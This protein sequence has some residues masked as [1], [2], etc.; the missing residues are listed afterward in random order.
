MQARI[1]GRPGGV[2]DLFPQIARLQRLHDATVAT[3]CQVPVAV[4]FD[5]A[6]EFVLQRNGIVGVLARNSQI[7]FRIPVCI[8]GLEL[9]VGVALTRELDHALDVVFRNLVLLCGL[10]FALQGRVLRRIEAIIIVRFAVD[11]SLH[12][13]GQMLLDDL[14]TGDERSNLLLF[15]DLPVD[16]FLDIR[17]IDVDDDHLGGAAGRA[18]R[19]D[20]TCGAVADLQEAHQTGGFATTGKFFTFAA[21]IAEVRARAGAILEQA[22]FTDP[23]IH[24][25]AFIDEI[26]ANGLNEAGMRLRMFIGRLG[27]GQFAGLPVDIEMALAGTVDAIGPMQTGVEPL[28]AVWSHTL[29]RE[30]I[31]KLV[32]EGE[33]IFLRGEIA[34]LPAPIGPGAGET[35]EN[36][37]GVHFGAV[38]L[39]FRQLGKRVLVSDRAPQP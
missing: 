37:A 21:Q 1:S 4:V 35:V 18:A 2:T 32:A 14:G 38:A 36:L 25:A 34:T 17:M 23:Q 12:D 9:N 39:I 11:T 33:G 6:Q 16:I 24:D 28:R 5:S 13:G 27:L 30:H 10:D 7:G 26:V 3:S 8:V 19:L 15:L 20:R 31:G 29:G 22:R